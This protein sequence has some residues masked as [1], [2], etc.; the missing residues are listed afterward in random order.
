[1]NNSQIYVGL[2]IG[3][4]SIKVLVCENVKG[5]LEVVGVG[6]QPSGGLSHGAIVD[7]DKTAQAIRTA[8]E[9]AKAKSGADIQTVTVG[10]PANYLKQ[11][12][13]H[14]MITVTDQGQPREIINQDVIDVAHSTL[15]QALPPEREVID[16]VPKDFAVD[17]FRGIKD[18]RGMAGV[19]L[20]LWAT[21]YSGSKTI[22]HNTKKA[23]AA[24]GLKLQDL[25]VG[26]IAT[27][28]NLLSDGEQDFGTLLMDF[29][30]G[31][32]T[33]SI[34][35]DHQLKFAYV[36]PEGGKYVTK[37]ISTVLNTSQK[38]AERLKLDHGY[39]LASIV[40]DDVE[41]AVDV[42][43]KSQ[44]VNYTEKYLAEII[45]ARMR[46]IFRRA[47]DRLEAINAPDL[48]GGLVLLGGAA[49]MPGLKELASEYF[50]GNIRVIVPEQMGIRHPGYATSLSLTMYEAN[51]SDVTRLIKRTLHDED[52][53][54]SPSQSRSQVNRPV[55]TPKVAAAPQ[56]T[57]SHVLANMRRRAQKPAQVPNEPTQ[58]EE[59]PT[60]TSAKKEKPS[61]RNFFS[62]FFD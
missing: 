37:D 31:Q 49:A 3:T 58:K 52:L 4:A 8:V 30:A 53:I 57:K 26:P 9:K 61:W 34:I 56:P 14:G 59:T 5:K 47:K 1:M 35:H 32:T 7:I 39:A 2:D 18:P 62:N 13:V 33:T 43:G 16:L 12:E 44:P 40:E 51:L 50:P 6:S 25:V 54:A 21:L 38:N 42:V 11:S 28:F 36:D 22:V 10:L 15:S 45:E 41:L 24:A 60:Q 20:E 17:Q 29:G 46:Q 23:V 48:P 55:P 27:G 19:R